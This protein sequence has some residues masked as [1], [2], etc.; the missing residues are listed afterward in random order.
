MYIIIFKILNPEFVITTCLSFIGIILTVY[1]YI[2]GRKFRQISYTY[3]TTNLSIN[4]MSLEGL[5]YVYEGKE[6][7][8][9]SVTDLIIWCSGKETIN[10]NDIAP[11]D[12]LKIYSEDKILSAEHIFSNE[13]CNNFNI[14]KTNDNIINVEFD[15]ISKNNGVTIRI[16]HEGYCGKLYVTGKI[17]DG[18]NISYISNRKGLF[19]KFINNR[20]VKFILSK[21]ITSF[22]FIFFTIFLFPNAFIQSAN[23]T[24]NNYFGLPQSSIFMNLDSIVI[25]ILCACSFFLSMPHLYNLFKVEPPPEL[26]N[27]IPCER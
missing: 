21:K 3:K 4:G 7:K 20:I 15:Y 23:Y 10:K 2:K 6:I 27:H 11:L 1:F 22:I 16:I 19:Y 5:S 14:L 9:I 26:I 24:D 18:K 17:K 13:Y 25:F 12:P 8:S